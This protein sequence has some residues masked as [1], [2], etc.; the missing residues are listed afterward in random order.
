MAAGAGWTG[1]VS[2][3][4]WGTG[5]EGSPRCT[6]LWMCALW[7]R[8]PRTGAPPCRWLSFG[9]WP[10]VVETGA[11]HSCRQGWAAL[12]PP[13]GYCPASHPSWATLAWVGCVVR[14]APTPAPQSRVKT[15]AP[16]APAPAPPALPLDVVSRAQ[17]EAVAIM[18]G[19]EATA[20]LVGVEA[21][22]V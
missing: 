4:G 19:V 18:V 8:F 22:A 17:L 20:L 16:P 3:R 14:P 1:A 10:L 9:M 12:N 15:Y 7:W 6:P 21:T 2:W 11:T 5:C 13:Q